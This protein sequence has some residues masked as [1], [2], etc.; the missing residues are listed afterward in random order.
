MPA[1]RPG[2]VAGLIPFTSPSTETWAPAGSVITVS[3]PVLTAGFVDTT[4]LALTA[5][6]WDEPT[7]IDWFQEHI[8]GIGQGNFMVSRAGP[9]VMIT[10][11][12]PSYWSS[13]VTEAPFGTEVTATDPFWRGR[14]GCCGYDR[15]RRCRVGRQSSWSTAWTRTVF[16]GST[17]ALVI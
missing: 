4:R 10:G 17:V 5:V 1:D 13:S 12:V 8:P 6:V 14:H 3:E 7:D 15:D 16:E 11:V 9:P 2:M